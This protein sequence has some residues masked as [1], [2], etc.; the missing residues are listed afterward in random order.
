MASSDIMDDSYGVSD[1]DVAATPSESARGEDADDEHARQERHWVGWG[2]FDAM[3][4]LCIFG[5]VGCGADEE[6]Q[7]VDITVG[8]GAA[9]VAALARASALALTGR[10]LSSQRQPSHGG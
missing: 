5:E 1:S 4:E 10:R 2:D 3:Q 7:L 8:S 9:E 6:S